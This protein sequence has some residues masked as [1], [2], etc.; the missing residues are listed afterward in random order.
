MI[1]STVSGILIYLT[2]IYTGEDAPYFPNV[3][4]TEGTLE[5]KEVSDNAEG[6]HWPKKEYMK[7]FLIKPNAQGQIVFDIDNGPK[8]KKQHV[9]QRPFNPVDINFDDFV[10]GRDYDEFTQWFVDGKIEADF[11]ANGFVNGD[12]MDLFSD[13]WKTGGIK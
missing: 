8:L 13:Y 3:I 1:I 4:V 12:D 2:K 6:V 10:N 5:A 7:A 11:D 9:S